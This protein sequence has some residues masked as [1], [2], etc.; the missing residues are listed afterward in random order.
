MGLLDDAI[1]EHLDLK[2]RRGADPAEIERAEREA[3]GPV[4]REPTMPSGLD[5]PPPAFA[6][7]VPDHDDFA[8]EDEFTVAEADPFT[9]GDLPGRANDFDR[10]GAD[11]SDPGEADSPTMLH[12]SLSDADSEHAFPA[13]PAR[14]IASPDYSDPDFDEFHA[15]DITSSR[16]PRHRLRGLFHRRS[17]EHDHDHDD[18]GAFAEDDP[19]ADDGPFPEHPRDDGRIGIDP[20]VAA[21][22]AGP[23]EPSAGAEPVLPL[24]LDEM[25]VADPE[26]GRPR[27]DQAAASSEPTDAGG[28]PP[29]Q[30]RP[31]HEPGQ[32]AEYDV[33]RIF[34][35]EDSSGE[36]APAE[37]PDLLEET[38]EFL[39]DTPDH[40]R[41][42]FEQKPPPDFDFE[43]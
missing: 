31:E 10:G 17:H 15:G 5:G 1:R 35:E 11:D 40:D 13:E 3:L 30:I 33:E 27:S 24:P 32:T 37:G 4:R 38:P 28:P 7:T 2:R 18:G 34:D 14:G 12:P 39:A 20:V 19:F 22:E 25:G 42:W 21:A 29:L 26:T 6:H 43:G 16:E 8:D 9:G 41:L 36:P 23:A